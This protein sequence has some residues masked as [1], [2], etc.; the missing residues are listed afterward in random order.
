MRRATVYESDGFKKTLTLRQNMTLVT[1]ESDRGLVHID[2]G[3]NTL[4][5]YIPRDTLSR[6]KCYSTD[7]PKALVRWLKIEDEAATATFRVVCCMQDD[8][9]EY[10]LDNDGI[11]T[12]ADRDTGESD[13]STAENE[14][15][16]WDE[17]IE[18]VDLRSSNEEG[19]AMH[20]GNFDRDMTTTLFTTPYSNGP[21][22]RRPEHA[23]RQIPF[24]GAP[25]FSQAPGTPSVSLPDDPQYVRLLEQVI[26]IA[27]R[28]VFPQASL[29]E[30]NRVSSDSIHGLASGIRSDSQLMHDRKIGAAGELYVCDS[31]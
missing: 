7:L 18:T 30:T 4:R 29:A 2:D 21:E 11:T 27:R 23:F 26:T 13:S 17:H 16:F 12:A 9:I 22:S 20:E 6:L 10:T 24:K 8:V 31:P 19:S 15:G 28:G 5:I 25:S 3:S 1:T 14:P